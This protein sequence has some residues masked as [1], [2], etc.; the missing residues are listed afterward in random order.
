[1]KEAK[2]SVSDGMFH[3]QKEYL[4]CMVLTFII[5]WLWIH[6]LGHNFVHDMEEITFDAWIFFS[7]FD[8]QIL[9]SVDLI[10]LS[11]FKS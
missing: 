6:L 1:M 2:L 3:F 7:R 4:A 9:S 10:R 11:N 5:S 8:I